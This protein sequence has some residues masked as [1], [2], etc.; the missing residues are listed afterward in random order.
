MLVDTTQN[1]K[2]D[3]IIEELYNITKAMQ[4][5][6]TSRNSLINEIENQSTRNLKNLHGILVNF[7]KLCRYFKC[8]IAILLYNI[9]HNTW[10]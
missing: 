10:T 6:M 8:S 7:L 4:R 1:N 9:Y 3:S 2:I 5:I